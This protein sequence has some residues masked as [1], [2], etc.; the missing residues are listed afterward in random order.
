LNR[1]G[2]LPRKDEVNVCFAHSAY[3]MAERFAARGT[4]IAHFQVR[5]PEDSRHA[6]P[7][8]GVIDLLLANLE[9]LWRSEVKLVTQVV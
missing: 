7:K 5:T 9:R 2:V 4:G 3:C 6:Y 1:E 8:D